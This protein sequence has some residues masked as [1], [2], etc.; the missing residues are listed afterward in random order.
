MSG[1]AGR[2]RLDGLHQHPAAVHRSAQALQPGREARFGRAV[3]LVGRAAAIARHRREDRQEAFAARLQVA[4]EQAQHHHRLGEVDVEVAAGFLRVLLGLALFE[5]PFLG[6]DDET[7]LEPGM[8]FALEPMLV[9][10]ALGTAVIEETV[11]VSE[12]GCEVLGE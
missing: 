5:L 10:Y 9:R 12:D 11:L 8:V 6:P 1:R 7:R 4:R 3:G 2:T